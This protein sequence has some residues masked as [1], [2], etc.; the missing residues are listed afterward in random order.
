MCTNPWTHMTIVA[1]IQKI[2]YIKKKFL[3]LVEQQ[4]NL[5]I[6]I[7]SLKYFENSHLTMHISFHQ[8]VICSKYQPEL[9]WSIVIANTNIYQ[10]HQYSHKQKYTFTY[11]S[12]SSSNIILD[13][14]EAFRRADG[15]A[16]KFTYF[17]FQL[18]DNEQ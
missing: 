2:A 4:Q 1:H 3:S 17:F 9:K 11:C 5:K 13:N 15:R 12:S 6:F 18:K 7:L 8:I 10:L 14:G 16:R